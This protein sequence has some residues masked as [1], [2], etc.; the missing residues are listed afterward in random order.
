MPVTD[1]Q[2]QRFPNALRFPSPASRG[3]EAAYLLREFDFT[4]GSD[5]GYTGGG[6]CR[7]HSRRRI[8]PCRTD[9]V[10]PVD[11]LRER[12]LLLARYEGVLVNDAVA[13]DELHL[14]QFYDGVERT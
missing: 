6:I 4:G 3:A 12:P 2:A 13:H 11:G 7:R 14:L 5:G 8:P 10:P 9:E 1:I